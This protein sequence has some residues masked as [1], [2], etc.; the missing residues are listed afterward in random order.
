MNKIIVFLLLASAAHSFAEE[1]APVVVEE[2]QKETDDLKELVNTMKQDRIVNKE[3][4]SRLRKLIQE[5][6]WCKKKEEI[7]IAQK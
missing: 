3:R 7:P 1:E 5:K 4:V 6:G 2:T